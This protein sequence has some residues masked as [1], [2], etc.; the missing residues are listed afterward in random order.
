MGIFEQR[1]RPKKDDLCVCRHPFLA[2]DV[3]TSFCIRRPC[4]CMYYVHL[5]KRNAKTIPMG[6]EHDENTTEVTQ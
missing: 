6:E 5:T 2:H 1:S 3:N 4:A